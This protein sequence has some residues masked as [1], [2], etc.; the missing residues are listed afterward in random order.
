MREEV[1][2]RQWQERFRAGMFESKATTVQCE[3]GWYDWFCRDEALAGRLKRISKVVMGI[4]EPFLLD[5]YYVWFKNNCPLDGP[6]YDDVRFEPLVGERD[7]RYFLVSLDCPHETQKWV[8]YTERYG[9]DA[10]EF[11]CDNIRDMV[12]YV[13]GLGREFAQNI[14][15][16]FIAEKA[17]LAQYI[18]RRTGIDGIHIFRD[19]EHRYQYRIPGD[20]TLRRAAVAH[21]VDALPA[22]FSTE[23]TTQADGFHICVQDI[24][25]AIPLQRQ[26]NAQ[27]K[28][29][30]QER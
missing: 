30:G 29:R 2:V 8:L 4:T 11:G 14:Q 17:A 18:A 10:P 13:N 1:S 19:G 24:G 26:K 5:N 21:D 16:P 12:K 3:A 22:E 6:L 7:G 28:K 9:Y 27:K 23:K 20:R 25:E 15:P